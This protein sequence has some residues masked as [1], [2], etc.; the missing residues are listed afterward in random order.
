MQMPF[1]KILKVPTAVLHGGFWLLYLLYE[2]FLKWLTEDTVHFSAIFAVEALLIAF[3]YLCL[4]G[5]DVAQKKLSVGISYFVVLFTML[6][7]GGYYFLTRFLPI[8]GLIITTESFTLQGYI[9]VVMAAS[10]KMFALSLLFFLLRKFYQK[11]RENAEI[12]QK[13]TEYKYALL[14]AQINPHFLFN[15]LN[16]LYSQSLPK[17][18]DVAENILKLSEMMRYSLDE[19]G[20]END[21]VSLREELDY[22]KK[23]RD[24]QR[25]RF[26]DRFLVDYRETGTDSHHRI[27]KMSLVSI[28]E[29]AIKYADVSHFPIKIS[30]ESSENSVSFVCENRKKK[31]VHELPSHQLGMKSL[32]ERLDF[33]FENQYFLTVEEDENNYKIQLKYLYRK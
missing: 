2:V 7:F 33:Y 32:R 8:F 5:F 3:F 24:F 6:F 22:L 28:L 12:L 18:P 16:F 10:V 20:A 11:Q 17:A 30:V 26:G 14:R 15:T 29:N 31:I 21:K 1:K 9:Q 23:L 19:N 27:L 4:F 25:L 13:Q